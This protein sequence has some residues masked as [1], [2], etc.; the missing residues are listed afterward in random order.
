MPLLTRV[1]G[2]P[3]LER[4]QRVEVDVLAIDEVDLSIELRLHRVL[5]DAAGRID[6]LDE[7]IAEVADAGSEAPAAAP[8]ADLPQ[9]G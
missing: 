3:M 7:E 8:A 6:E 5:Q 9:G 2:L 1:V 4:G